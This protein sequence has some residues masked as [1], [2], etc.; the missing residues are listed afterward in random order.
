MNSEKLLS[1]YLGV[2]EGDDRHD[3]EEKLLSSPAFLMDYITLKRSFEVDA[4][5]SADPAADPAAEPVADPV[6]EMMPKRI[7]SSAAAARLRR[8]VELQFGKS[9]SNVFVIRMAA[10]VPA[11][12][13]AMLLILVGGYSLY[14]KSQHHAPSS[15]P[16]ANRVSG[17]VDSSG[18]AAVSLSLL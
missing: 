7:P 13:A 11:A 10:W 8:E 9:K 4:D 12:I 1:Y 3:I 16:V 18:D 17:A 14:A 2:L 15:E 6:V 5:L